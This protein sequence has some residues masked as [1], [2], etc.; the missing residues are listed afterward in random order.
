MIPA[1]CLSAKTFRIKLSIPFLLK[2]QKDKE[3]GRVRERAMNQM[4]TF[5]LNMKSF[6]YLYGSRTKSEKIQRNMN[7]SNQNVHIFYAMQF[8]LRICFR[9]EEEKSFVKM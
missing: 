2:H 4:K 7:N 8:K 5:C 9:G 6:G 1:L 3:D